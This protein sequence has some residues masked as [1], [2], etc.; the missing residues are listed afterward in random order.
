M[1]GANFDS[2]CSPERDG[3]THPMEVTQNDVSGPARK[4]C[5]EPCFCRRPD[6]ELTTSRRGTD[7]HHMDTRVRLY[8]STV[9]LAAIAVGL[10]V[11]LIAADLLDLTRTGEEKRRGLS[12]RK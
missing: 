2:T 7:L 1:S 9:V 4:R 8:V 6:L 3:V 11:A 10:T 12:M 5:L